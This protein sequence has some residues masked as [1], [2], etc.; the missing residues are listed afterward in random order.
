VIA[1]SSSDDKLKIATKLGAKYVIN[2]KTTTEWDQ[3]VL[4][5]TNG[6][7]VDHVIEVNLI[8]SRQ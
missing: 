4:R 1:T 8:C 5:L 6:R 7:G 2:Y 3:Q